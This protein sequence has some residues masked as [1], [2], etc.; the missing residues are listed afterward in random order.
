MKLD[1]I[2]LLSTE[3]IQQILRGTKNFTKE[4]KGIAE[5]INRVCENY[6]YKMWQRLLLISRCVL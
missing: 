2:T 5:K 1:N 6:G 3:M 4:Q